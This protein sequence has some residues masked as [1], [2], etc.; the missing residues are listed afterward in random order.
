[1]GAPSEHI[2]KFYVDTVTGSPLSVRYSCDFFG[3]DQVMHG[4]DHPFFPMP[5]GPELLDRVGLTAGERAKV[6]HL[7]AA[8]FFDLHI[9]ARRG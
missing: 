4:T 7:N 2:K 1:M 3:I 5:S 6:D 8:R 9:P